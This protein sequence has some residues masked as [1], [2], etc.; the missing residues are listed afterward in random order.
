MPATLYIVATPIGNLA[1]ITLRAIDTLKKVD[2]IAVEDTRHS[3]FLLQQY[4]ITT[5]MV[6][7][8]EHSGDGQTDKLFA[9]LED[10]KSIA[11][12]SDAGTPLISDPGYKLVQKI[13][14]MNGLVVP[15]PGASAVL[16]AL[17]ASGLA[18]D[19][20]T[21]I[22]FL[23]AK[24]KARQD[25]LSLLVEKTETL[26]IYE[27]PH[28]I[29][30]TLADLSLIFGAERRITLARELTKTFE[31]I[32]QLSMQ[33]MLEWVAADANQQRGE[34]VL[35]VEGAPHKL[36]FDH[37]LSAEVKHLSQ[38]LLSELPPKTISKIVAAHYDVPKK[39]VYDYV[40]SLKKE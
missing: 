8:H 37:A 3:A 1:D 26:I 9:L 36:A 10:G 39:L 29:L 21:F 32:R 25:T 11:L 28:R 23:P 14:Q 7:Y 35:I 40:L 30:A 12:I 33:Q 38:Q 6:A 24:S 16:S 34:I 19:Q 17:C 15:I 5:P 18:T 31:T 20:F 2:I 4:G 27:A 13:H 22:G